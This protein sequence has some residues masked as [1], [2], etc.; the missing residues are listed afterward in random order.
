MIGISIVNWQQQLSDRRGQGCLATI[1]LTEVKSK[2]LSLSYGYWNKNFDV[3]R[4]KLIIR[5]AK[6][7][8]NKSVLKL[9][10]VKSLGGIQA[11][12]VVYDVM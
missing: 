5:F 9:S 2:T 7:S 8:L 12:G 3:G 6:L 4:T 1:D 10:L 11:C